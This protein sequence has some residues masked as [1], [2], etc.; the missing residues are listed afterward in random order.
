[1]PAFARTRRR[2]NDSSTASDQFNDFRIG[3][4]V[5]SLAVMSG[6]IGFL[7]WLLPVIFK[8]LADPKT[9]AFLPENTLPVLLIAGTGALLVGLAALVLVLAQ[10]GLTGWRYPLGLPDGSIRAVIALLLIVLFFITAVFLYVDAGRGTSRQ[11]FGVDAQRLAGIPTEQIQD[12]RASAHSPDKFDVVLISTRN[13]ASTD[14]AK[15][16]VTTVSTLVVAV[17]AFYFGSSAVQS[18]HAGGRREDGGREKTP[19]DGG[20]ADSEQAATPSAATG[21]SEP[22]PP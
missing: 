10:L 13:S 4:V 1:V 9:H 20:G 12:L 11:L 17:A 16:L 18:A 3:W 22:S 21:A 2:S 19:R 14:I 7:L 8:K 5:F 6:L 15:Q